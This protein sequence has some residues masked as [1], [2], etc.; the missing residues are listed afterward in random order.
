MNLLINFINRIN[1]NVEALEVKDRYESASG[2]ESNSK[3]DKS[4]NLQGILFLRVLCVLE[5]LII[6]DEL[7]YSIFGI[8]F[9][10]MTIY[11]PF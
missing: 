3:R 8:Y 6:Y 2:A 4:L 7:M 9:I 1:F 10:Y 5:P 11:K